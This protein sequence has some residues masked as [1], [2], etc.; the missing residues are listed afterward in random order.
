MKF[1]RFF[2]MTLSRKVIAVIVLTTLAATLTLIPAVFYT[3]HQGLQGQRQRHLTGVRHLVERLIEENRR[4][5]KNYAVLF[6]TDRQIKDNLYY[7]AELAGEREHPLN[8][9][10]HLVEAFGLR[11]I[12]LGDRIGVVVAD[13][14]RP[15]R[16]G[17]D[18]SGNPLIG[19]ALAGRVAVGIEPH[20]D[21]F[22][23]MAVAPIFHDEGQL[24]GTISTGIALDNDFAAMIRALSGAEIAIADKNGRVIAASQAGMTG[25]MQPLSQA[26]STR[27]AGTA[28]E[29]LIMTLPF[30]DFRD[31]PLGQVIIMSKDTLPQIL[32][33]ANIT[34]LAVLGCIALGSILVTVFILR[35]MLAPIEKLKSGAE[36]IGCGQFQ[37]RIEVTSLDEIGG[38]A[39]VFNRMAVNLQQM[40]E[41]EE[42]LK[43]AE[44]LASIGEFTA[45]TAHE[46][47]NPIANII[48]LA[49]VVRKDLPADSRLAEDLDLLVK[50]SGRCGA[51]VRD[52]LLYSRAARPRRE[53]VDLNRPLD[54]AIAALAQRHLA[55][56]EIRIDFSRLPSSVS[57]ISVDPV[58]IE[59]VFSNLLLNAAQAISGPGIIEVVITTEPDGFLTVRIAD[60]GGGI[61]PEHLDKVFYPF[62]TTKKSGEGT[63]LGLAVSYTIVQAHGGTITAV[64]RPEGGAVFTVK[65]PRE[66]EHA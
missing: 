54:E 12:E 3:L 52:L 46:L 1:P 28:G 44:R 49:K 64:N 32:R 20:P 10:R 25:A 51:I 15:E 48:G 27:G 34:I 63:G 17:E 61:L 26:G 59:Q 30:A 19:E 18:R 24:I 21:G 23:L 36:K 5:V 29:Y 38:L 14:A 39:E 40:R 37:H 60:S 50:E 62:F 13:A 53:E 35:R 47:N 8:A 66:K 57:R 42:K 33:Q 58:Q 7:Y 55:G 11:H 43:H 31:S 2:V 41:V 45:A 6:G 9:V 56:G 4:T 16:F 65:L 22:L